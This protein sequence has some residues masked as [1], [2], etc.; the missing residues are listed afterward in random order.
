MIIF[1]IVISIIAFM[2]IIGEKTDKAKLCFTL[3]F[4]TCIVGAILLK[5]I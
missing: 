5:L 1:L 4:I 3:A 2:G